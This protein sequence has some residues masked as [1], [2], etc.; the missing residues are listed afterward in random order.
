MKPCKEKSMNLIWFMWEAPQMFPISFL[1]RSYTLVKRLKG[2]GSTDKFLHVVVFWTL[3]RSNRQQIIYDPRKL[4]L[5]FTTVYVQS[6][7]NSS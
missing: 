3:S 5:D 4:F 6:A 7:L 1:P 2:K